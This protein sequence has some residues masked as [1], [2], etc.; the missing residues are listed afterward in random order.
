MHPVSGVQVQVSEDESVEELPL[1]IFNSLAWER[2]ELIRIIIKDNVQ[3]DDA[4]LPLA[5]IV[6]DEGAAIP[7]QVHAV[8]VNGTQCVSS[9]CDS[10]QYYNIRTL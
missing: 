9:A 2:T 8:H 5:R 1:I 3:P 7:C 10:L 6:S 4:F